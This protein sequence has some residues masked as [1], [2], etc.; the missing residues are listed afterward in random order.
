MNRDRFKDKDNINV[1]LYIVTS[2]KE[3]QDFID[4]LYQADIETYKK[5]GKIL[6]VGHFAE[7]NLYI[8]KKPSEGYITVSKF[9]GANEIRFSPTAENQMMFY[10]EIAKLLVDNEEDE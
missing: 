8:F 9:E 3:K 6:S 4:K 2:E 7:N 10:T 5:G 1:V